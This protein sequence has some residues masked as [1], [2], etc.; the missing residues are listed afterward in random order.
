MRAE[1]ADDAVATGSPRCSD[2]DRPAASPGLSS[3]VKQSC[4]LLNSRLFGFRQ[5]EVGKQPPAENREVPDKR[6]LDL[7]E[8]AHE[9][10]QRRARHAV[11]Q[12]EV[13]VFLLGQGSDQASHC[14][15]FVS[16]SG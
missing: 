11:G 1:R 3:R 9:T 16:W 7:A 15:E 4:R 14:H 8:P 5:I 12:E 10:G 2:R 13:E 6:V